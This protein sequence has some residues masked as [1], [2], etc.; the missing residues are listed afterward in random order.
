MERPPT[1]NPRANAEALSLY[2]SARRQ[3]RKR[4]LVEPLLWTRLHLE[5][6]S[7]SFGDC[8]PA[9]PA[10]MQLPS[11]EEPREDAC[12]RQDFERYFLGPSILCGTVKETIMRGLLCLKPSPLSSCRDLYLHLGGN[13]SVILPCTYYRLGDQIPLAAHVDLGRILA[14]RR[15]RLGVP[16]LKRNSIATNNLSKLKIRSVTPP[17]PLH[18]PYLVALL[19]ALGQ[20]QWMALGRPKPQQAAGVTPKLL[21]ST[22]DCSYI[23][24]LSANISSSLINFFHHP[25]V[26]PAAADPLT[27]RISSVPYK[28]VDTLRGRLMALLLST[29][30]IEELDKAENLILYT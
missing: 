27:V 7:C 19:I 15:A 8:R 17:E 29:T 6:L 12:L 14:L 4:I 1:S 3:P 25:A 26:K 24:I 20:L 22:A 21:F 2:E 13:R 9:P 18:D 16:M 10:M 30:S 5:I 11:P 23:Y 28:P